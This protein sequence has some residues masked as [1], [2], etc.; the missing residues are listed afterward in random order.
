G[1][2]TGQPGRGLLRRR[3]SRGG[4]VSEGERRA[5][6]KALRNA[7]DAAVLEIV[8]T[9]LTEEVDPVVTR[10]LLAVRGLSGIA[11]QRDRMLDVFRNG[12]P[13]LAHFAG[14]ALLQNPSQRFLAEVL[15]FLALP[16]FR[17]L[18]NAPIGADPEHLLLAYGSDHNPALMVAGYL[19]SGL[20]DL[21]HLVEA[22]RVRVAG[23]SFADATDPVARFSR[24][25]ERE[26]GQFLGCQAAA[27]PG[28]KE[29]LARLWDLLSQLDA[30]GDNVLDLF[31]SYVGDHRGG[32][33]RALFQGFSSAVAKF[34]EGKDDRDLPELDAIAAGLPAE[35]PLVGPLRDVFHR[36]RISLR[37]ECRDFALVTEV[38]G[39]GDV[40]LI[41]QLG[42]GTGT[43]RS[44]G[45]P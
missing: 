36:A 12:Q 11:R 26:L 42:P 20:L 22:L 31:L 19:D 34:I 39:R 33:Q 23:W 38:A 37:I 29:A 35:G 28:Q 43:T 5:L 3:F 45:R 40:V 18:D 10:H 30:Q 2:F 4:G 44:R 27:Q 21:G 41:E 14:L 15:Q 24:P 6:A 8:G 16:G 7:T 9:L 13:I 25:E 32:A 17:Q 1:R